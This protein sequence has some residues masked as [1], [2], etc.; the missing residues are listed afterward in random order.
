[1]PAEYRDADWAAEAAAGNAGEGRK[2]F[3]T[4][5]CAKCH[6]I[7]PKDVGGGAPNLADRVTREAYSHEVS[8]CGFWPGKGLGQ[9]AFYS[10]AYPEPAGLP[11]ASIG[12]E[13]AYYSRELHEFIL[14]YDAVCRAAAP[15]QFVLEFLEST[16]A[17]AADLGHWDRAA[18]ER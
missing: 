16:Y 11:D 14:P 15:D 3:D 13:A 2:L 18:L 12:P 7:Q 17:A 5:G 6:A 1:M 10:Y 9:P 4:R 8:S